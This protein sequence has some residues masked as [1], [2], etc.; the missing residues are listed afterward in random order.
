MPILPKVTYKINTIP[1]RIWMPFFTEL[2]K[3]N[4]EIHMEAQRPWITSEILSKKT[5]AGGIMISGFK[6]YYKTIVI[7]TMW[8]CY[9]NG[10]IDQQNRIK[11]PVQISRANWL[12]AKVWGDW[13]YVRKAETWSLSLTLFKTQLKVDQRS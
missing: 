1:I 13:Y 9:S 8:Y 2:E 6:I 12:S 10:H 11:K 4:P 5:K 3:N 7:K